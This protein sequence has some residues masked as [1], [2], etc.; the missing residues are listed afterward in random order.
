MVL[1]TVAG[2]EPTPTESGAKGKI[3]TYICLL[4]VI[5]RYL[6]LEDSRKVCCPTIRLHRYVLRKMRLAPR[7]DFE[8]QICCRNEGGKETSFMQRPY[9]VFLLIT[10]ILY[11]IFFIKSIAEL[12]AS[13]CG[14]TR[15]RSYICLVALCYWLSP[16]SARYVL[17]EGQRLELW[18][19]SA[20][21]G[22]FQD[23]CLTI[24]LTLHIVAP[25]PHRTCRVSRPL[26]CY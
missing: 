21:N 8:P 4:L 7:K 2:I 12:I 24:R 25:S 26:A 20:P 9:F 14:N 18:I 3:W 13:L 10:Y 16:D 6:A 23:C 11:H 22:S 19:G 5:T 15:Y 17:A 1:A